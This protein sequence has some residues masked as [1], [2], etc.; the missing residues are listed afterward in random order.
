MIPDLKDYITQISSRQSS[1][2]IDD[3]I[4]ELTEDFPGQ[5]TFSTSFGFEDQVI[6]HI[7]LSNKIP[8]SIFTLDTGRLFPETYS[9]WN[10]TNQKYNTRI[11]PYYPQHESLEQFVRE[12]GPNSF[13]DSVENRKQCCFIRKVE[14]LKRALAG[15]AV[16]ITGLRA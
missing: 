8:V 9:V 12:K 6:S 13:Y 10:S 5:V 1:A 3:S 11:I 15:K 7:I 14:P 4:L 16:W 2:S